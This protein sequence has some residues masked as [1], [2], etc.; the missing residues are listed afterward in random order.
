[1]QCVAAAALAALLA[2]ATARA[3]AGLA[4]E[5]HC[6]NCH[7][8]QRKMV[9]PSVRDIAARYGRSGNAV[10]PVLAAKVRQGGSGA[11][12]A[13]AMPSHPQLTQAEAETLV[14]W[15]LAHR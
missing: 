12:G 5:R 9:G 14:R 15:M 3:D 13:V 10:V 1:M 8:V 2:P 11:W 7:A 4:R 6:L